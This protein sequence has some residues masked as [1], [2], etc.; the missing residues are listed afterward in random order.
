MACGAAGHGAV[1]LHEL[2]MPSSIEPMTAALTAGY[3]PKS[4]A[5][6]MST[7]AS[8]G[9]PSSSLDWAGCAAV[10]GS[11]LPLF[12]F[13]S[14]ARG[15]GMRQSSGLQIGGDTIEGEGDPG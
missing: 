10:V 7:R 9:R 8:R 5:L 12:V 3:I 11:R 4:S 15:G 1:R 14:I 13:P 2:A 6:M